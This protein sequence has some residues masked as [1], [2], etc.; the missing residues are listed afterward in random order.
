MDE[1]VKG[2]EQGN[3][4]DLTEKSDLLLL[5]AS[6]ELTH[7]GGEKYLPLTRR[8]PRRKSTPKHELFSS[9]ELKEQEHWMDRSEHQFLLLQ[10][11]KGHCRT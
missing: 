3:H 6:V 2:R 5:R 4:S 9:T 7:S 11:H 1:A 10:K 8:S